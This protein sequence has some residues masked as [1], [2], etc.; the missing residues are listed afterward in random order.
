[1]SKK[2]VQFT[3]QNQTEE[4]ID[5]IILE[6]CSL[7][8]ELKNFTRSQ[9]SLLIDKQLVTLNQKVVEK[10]GARVKKDDVVVLIIPQEINT[11]TLHPTAIPLDILYE[12][13]HLIVINK[14]PSL[15]V[16]P[17]AGNREHTLVNALIYHQSLQPSHFEKI[18][19]DSAGNSYSNEEQFRPGIVHRLDKDTSGIIVVAKNPYIH[20]ELSLQFKS[21]KVE[22]EY[23]ALILSS[24][25]K[26]KDIDKMDEGTIDAL[27]ARDSRHRLK[28]AVS[29]DKGRRSLTHWKI[30]E[31][32]QYA[33]LVNAGLE[34][35]RT[36]QIRV[37]FDY[38]GSPIIGDKLYGNFTSLPY[39]LLKAS[40]HFGRQ[41]LHASK[42]SFIHPQT[43][44]KM[45]FNAPLPCDFEELLKKFRAI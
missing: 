18:A 2:L 19:N 15:T 41:A 34:T 39:V 13:E 36:H 33:N 4:R 3:A 32:M 44:E 40:D 43:R 24:P 20:N 23:T 7:N 31:R 6:H 16:H 38:I 8:E 27:I 22:K 1:M 26:K 35:G 25:K 21:R 45:L 37:H 12:D 11:S 30:I 29:V 28:Y 42:L 10:N 14:Q 5:K 17:G 9:I